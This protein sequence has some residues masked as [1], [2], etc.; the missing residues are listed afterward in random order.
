[1]IR[2]VEQSLC[3]MYLN[4]TANSLTVLC[5]AGAEYKSP[6]ADISQGTEAA[7]SMH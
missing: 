7:G 4:Q 1:M 6:E 3:T 2:L 5:S